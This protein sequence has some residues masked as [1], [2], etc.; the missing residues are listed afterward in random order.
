MIFNTQV[1]YQIQLHK[2]LYPNYINCILKIYLG[3]HFEGQQEISFEDSEPVLDIS[4]L[5]LSH[6]VVILVIKPVSKTLMFSLRNVCIK[7]Y[8]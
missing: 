1:K 3:V 5:M 8:H 4:I 7:L 6:D 2:C